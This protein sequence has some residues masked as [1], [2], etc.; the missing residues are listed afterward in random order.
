MLPWLLQVGKKNL[1]MQ[2]YKIAATGVKKLSDDKSV[3]CHK[4]KYPFVVFY[5]HKA[6]MTSV[7]AVPLQGED[8][9]RA[10]AVAVCHKNTSAWNPNHLAF[11]VLKVKPGTV[12]VC[13]FLPETHVVWFNY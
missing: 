3:V 2:S 8:G 5:C 13:H 4:Q 6:K 7:Y 12:P 11:K 1:A 10:K 9:T